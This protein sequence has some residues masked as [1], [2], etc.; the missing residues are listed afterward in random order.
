MESNVQC[1]V[2]SVYQIQ[3][4]T[5]KDSSSLKNKHLRKVTALP[6][7]DQENFSRMKKMALI[8]KGTFSKYCIIS[9]LFLKF[10][11]FSQLGHKQDFKF[12][13]LIHS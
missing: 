9:L 6:T 2:F 13:I 1:D 3:R 7:V 11:N 8:S 4:E 10:Q 12:Y 5:Q